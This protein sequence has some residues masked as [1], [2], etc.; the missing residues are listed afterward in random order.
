MTSDF[1]DFIKQPAKM[2]VLFGPEA[3]TENCQTEPVAGWGGKRLVQVAVEVSAMEGTD[4]SD[5]LDIYIMRGDGNTVGVNVAHMQVVGDATPPQ[6]FTAVLD[7]AT[8]T[9][10]A[11][12][13]DVSDDCAAGVVRP[14]VQGDQLW[15][16]FKPTWETETPAD[17]PAPDFVVTVVAIGE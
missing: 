7:H 17:D 13:V 9:P 12:M 1:W 15:V 8:T 14:W 16:V 6:R 11:T 10:G 3:V 2:A 4:S 5:T